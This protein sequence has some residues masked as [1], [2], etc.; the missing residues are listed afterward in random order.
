M[1]IVTL[2]PE[3]NQP[4]KVPQHYWSGCRWVDEHSIDLQRRYPDKWVAVFEGA[5][6]AAG[7]DLGEVRNV[8]KEKTGQTAIYVEFIEGKPRFYAR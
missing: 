2:P 6:V 3:K 4:N 7:T 5:V 1:P 8:A